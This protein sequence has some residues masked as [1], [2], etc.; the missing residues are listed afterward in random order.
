[1][2]L[3]L[4]ILFSWVTLSCNEKSV[5]PILYTKEVSNKGRLFSLTYTKDST[6]TA[7]LKNLSIKN[8]YTGKTIQLINL[9]TIEIDEKRI[10]LSIDEDVNFDGHNDI[11]VLNYT[12]AYNSCYSFWLY[13]SSTNSFNH[14]KILDEVNNPIILKEKKE[15]CSKYRVGLS[16]FYLK[17]Y[18]W[19]N[20]TLILKEKYEELWSE[21]GIFKIIKLTDNGY[22][23]KDSIIL[24]RKIE[25]MNCE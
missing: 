11:Q 9:D 6:D 3:F 22:I 17:K 16:E 19:K 24:D 21:N 23:S 15:I 4:L 18:F 12:G 8:I 25:A 10:F 20:N 13:N 1:M 2:K 14:Y 5:Y 7:I